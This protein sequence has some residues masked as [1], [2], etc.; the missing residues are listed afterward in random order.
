VKSESQMGVD[1]ALGMLGTIGRWQVLHYTMIGTACFVLP[2][3]HALAIIYI[4]TWTHFSVDDTRGLHWD[5][6]EGILAVMLWG[7]RGKGTRCETPAW[8]ES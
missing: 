6:H 3:F 5:R 7:S 1:E 4:G 2:C 8:L